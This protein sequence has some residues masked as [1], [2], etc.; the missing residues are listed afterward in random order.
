L[1]NPDG[2]A[3]VY[4][5]ASNYSSVAQELKPL[6]EPLVGGLG[7]LHIRAL[8]SPAGLL[9]TRDTRESITQRMSDDSTTVSLYHISLTLTK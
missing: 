7:V 5:G 9:N 8:L 2:T 4:P 3:S 6:S 1:Q